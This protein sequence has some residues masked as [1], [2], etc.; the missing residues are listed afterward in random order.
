MRTCTCS[1]CRRTSVPLRG[2]LVFFGFCSCER[3]LH[4]ARDQRIVRS[5]RQ[6]THMNR[7]RVCAE[8]AMRLRRIASPM[9]PLRGQSRRTRAK[10]GCIS[11]SRHAAEPTGG[12]NEPGTMCAWWGPL[13]PRLRRVM[14]PR[15]PLRGQL[16]HVPD[17]DALATASRLCRLRFVQMIPAVG[18]LRLF[19]HFQNTGCYSQ[20]S[21]GQTDDLDLKE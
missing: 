16:P 11:R 18:P 1:N 20:I 5:S 15:Q 19:R 17:E 10:T 2:N 21:L 8:L 3:Q 4:D 13:G 7:G 14:N 6:K 9:W 12:A